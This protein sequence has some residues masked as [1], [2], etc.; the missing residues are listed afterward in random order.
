MV[1]PIVA[2]AFRTLYAFVLAELPTERTNRLRPVIYLFRF[3]NVD[4][5]SALVAGADIIF[6]RI[7]SDTHISPRF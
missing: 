7:A 3:L 4:A 6:Y 2:A 1:V 5:F